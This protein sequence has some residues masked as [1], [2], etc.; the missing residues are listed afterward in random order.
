MD[1]LLR[2]LRERVEREPEI[3]VFPPPA[4]EDAIAEVETAIGRSLPEDY[5]QFLRC[6]DGGFASLYLSSAD[7]SWD[8]GAS[9]WNSNVLFGTERLKTEYADQRDIWQLDLGWQGP[10]PYIPFCHTSGQELLVFAPGEGGD[11]EGV[12]RDAFHEVGP[13][14]WGLVYPSFTA[15]LTA[16]LDGHGEVA[17]IGER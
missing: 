15:F 6:F 16:Y 9:E 12:V 14:E 2:R 11:G 8:L 5:K 7:P 17:T 3:W 1:D 10:W 13:E 4:F